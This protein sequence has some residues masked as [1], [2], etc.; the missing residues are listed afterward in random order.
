[1]VMQYQPDYSTPVGETIRE[2]MEAEGMDQMDLAVAM[3]DEPI[4]REK[5]GIFHLVLDFL[6]NLPDENM[7]MDLETAQGLERAFNVPAQFWINRAENHRVRIH[8]Q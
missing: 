7:K 6:F 5:I 3:C 4:T 1:M 8:G 2:A